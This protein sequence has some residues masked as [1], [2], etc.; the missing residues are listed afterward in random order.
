MVR[1]NTVLMRALL[2]CLICGLFSVVYSLCPHVV[3]LA[4]VAFPALN[5][6]NRSS[7]LSLSLHLS[8]WISPLI[9]APQLFNVFLI[10]LCCFSFFSGFIPD[11]LGLGV[12]LFMSAVSIH[13]STYPSLH[14]L[15]RSSSFFLYPWIHPI[16]LSSPFTP[17][18]SPF[19]SPYQTLS[20]SL[21]CS[22]ALSPLS[23]SLQ[24]HT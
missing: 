2:K 6:S 5:L 17:P 21:P 15:F 12:S 11:L 19:C 9:L 7:C 20:L 18:G 3:I 13:P 23:F 14:G 4:T 1:T 10:S 24:L 8:S 16:S 22:I